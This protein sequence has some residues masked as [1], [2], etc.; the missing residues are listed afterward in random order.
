MNAR[1]LVAGLTVA[2]TAYAPLAS[3]AT[4]SEIQQL[5]DEM[6]ALR[7]DYEA[8]I[9]ALETRLAAAEATRRTVDAGR[10]CAVRA[11]TAGAGR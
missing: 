7:S 9:G 5:R 4:D 6:A 11:T 10:T 2:A 8:R 3:A 1:T